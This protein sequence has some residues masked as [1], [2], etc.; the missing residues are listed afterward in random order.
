[1]TRLLARVMMWL[2]LI[3]VIVVAG[4]HTLYYLMGWEWN[5]AAIAGVATVG[6][7]VLASSILL[8]GRLATVE[9]K[10]DLLLS[11]QEA[12]T[13]RIGGPVPSRADPTAVEVQLEPRPDLPWLSRPPALALGLLAVAPREAPDAAVFIPVF[14][15]A[16]LIISVLAG[17]VERVAA[18]V[19][20]RRARRVG[21]TAAPTSSRTHGRPRPI[22]T[23]RSQPRWLLVL[24]PF[25]GALLIGGAIGGLYWASHY[26]SE[27][28][29][30]GVTTMT[31]VVDARGPTTIDIDVVETVG[32]Y[33]TVDTGTGITFAGVAPGPEAGTTLLRLEP[34]LDEDAQARYIGCLQDA[35]LEWHRL[36][37]T[38]TEL[39]PA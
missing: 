25:L 38:R 14:L 15:A 8:L 24:V 21:V 33:C 27:P 13:S 22:E 19:Q 30:P 20:G 10:L 17:A 18:V 37:V 32:R 11:R 2:A 3:A 26:W 36:S 12:G 28:I 1:M 6:G 39:D 31:V 7:L 4:G 16:G 29:G 35:V 5:R 23:L 9:A 34:L